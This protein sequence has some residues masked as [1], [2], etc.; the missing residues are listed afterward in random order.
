LLEV[1]VGTTDDKEQNRVLGKA[2]AYN[3]MQE[4]LVS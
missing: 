4:G 1:T 3:I 2:L